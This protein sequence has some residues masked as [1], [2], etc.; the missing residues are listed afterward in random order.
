MCKIIVFIN[1]HPSVGSFNA[2]FQ[3]YQ[4]YMKKVKQERG[5]SPLFKNLSKLY[6]ERNLLKGVL[7]P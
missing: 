2:S 3:N 7:K 4:I 5:F 1:R 6:P